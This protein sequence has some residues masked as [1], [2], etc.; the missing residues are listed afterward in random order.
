MRK[1]INIRSLILLE[2]SFFI[3]SLSSM[4]S[5]KAMYNNPTISHVLFFYMLS[6]CTLGVYAI[7]WQ[8]VLK[9]LELSVA[10]ANKGI[11]IIWGL[12]WG[13]LI[14]N[15]KITIG[16]IIGAMLVIVGII[17]MMN[18]KEEKE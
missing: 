9:K 10:F 7:I 11:T 1:K 12:I 3:Y 6:L 13:L 15:E 18:N 4:F 14:F 16:M 5:K 2:I 17:V 8:Q